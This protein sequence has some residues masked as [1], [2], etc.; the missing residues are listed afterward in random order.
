MLSVFF[1]HGLQRKFAK[2]VVLAG[3]DDNVEQVERRLLI[4]SDNDRCWEVVIGF[5]VWVQSLCR[6]ATRFCFR[7]DVTL[8]VLRRN[9]NGIH[10][11]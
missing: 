10:A 11:A 5:E 2:A 1:I 7:F 3:L 8:N 4:G 9:R 6:E